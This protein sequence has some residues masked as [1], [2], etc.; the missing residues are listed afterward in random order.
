MPMQAGEQLPLGEG[1]GNMDWN[2][3]RR[4]FYFL[5]RKSPASST[6]RVSSATD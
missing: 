6:K 5:G 2:H 1:G 4:G 3:Q